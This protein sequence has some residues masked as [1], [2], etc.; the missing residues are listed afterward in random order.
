MRNA[1]KTCAL[2]LL[3]VLP[4]GAAAHD[5]SRVVTIGGALTEIVFALGE[6]D[7][8][9]ARD[10]TSVYPE[11]VQALPDIG[12][13]RQLSPEGV[14][15]VNPSLIIALEGSGPPAAVEVLADARVPMVTIP[16][17]HDETGIL[18]K[19]RL[20]GQALGV[21][22]KADAL[23]GEVRASLDAA[24]A[25]VAQGAEHKRVLFVLSLAGGRVMA[26]GRDTAA[27]ALIRMAGGQNV[28][29]DFEGYRQVTDEAIIEAA[30]EI[31]VMMGEG[32]PPAAEDDAVFGHPAIA[33]T[34]AGQDRALIRID[35]ANLNFGPRTA[36]AV[37][38]LAAQLH[39]AGA[40]G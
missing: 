27:D 2:A 21:E 3:P 13:I 5:T 35:G 24:L 26:S 37:R 19:I 4:L 18:E 11:A 36:D 32:G 34:P 29:P 39:D 16:D 12:Y 1:L 9:V 8:L 17:R 7:R 40:E 15:S 6:Q 20:V 22:D 38:G 30:P 31:I 14:L 28:I 25:E 23:S 33:P 10:S